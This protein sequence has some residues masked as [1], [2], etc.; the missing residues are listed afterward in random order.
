[1]ALNFE[2]QNV[3]RIEGA[4]PKEL[5]RLMTFYNSS[6]TEIGLAADAYS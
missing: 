6:M 1:M 2:L 3:T 5:I 4:S